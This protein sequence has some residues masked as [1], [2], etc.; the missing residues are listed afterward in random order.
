MRWTLNGYEYKGHLQ[1]GDEIN[2]HDLL[3][4]DGNN[5]NPMDWELNLKEIR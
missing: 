5:K 2:Q 1:D 3:Y 4:Q